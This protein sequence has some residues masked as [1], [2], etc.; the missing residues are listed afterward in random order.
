ME[1]RAGSG[2]AVFAQAVPAV[3]ETGDASRLLTPA[4]LA[5]AVILVLFVG[6]ASGYVL[7][8]P[9]WDNP[10][11]PAHYNY[12]R[13]LATGGGI[14][15]L[16]PGDW[17]QALLGG[18]MTRRF[19]PD[20]GVERLRYE[21]HQPPLYY[22]LM[23][24]FYRAAERLGTNARVVSLR[25]VNVAFAVATLVV[26][27]AATRVLLPRRPWLAV[28]AA[29]VAA[30]IPM[31]TAMSATI[32]NDPLSELLASATLFVLLLGVRD[33]FR[34]KLLLSLGALAGLLLLTKVTTYVFVV[35][36][37]AVVAVTSAPGWQTR[38][39]RLSRAG[40]RSAGVV[41][42]IATLLSG[43]WFVRG[44]LVYGP[45]DPLGL[46]RHDQVVVGQPRPVPG[47]EAVAF[48]LYSTSRSFWAQFGWM[49]VVV[50]PRLYVLA[51]LLLALAVL[52]LSRCLRGLHLQPLGPTAWG[53]RL[54][55]A[56]L[57][58]VAG[59]VVLYNFSF[60]QAQGRYLYPAILPIAV[61]VALGWSVLA[62]ED[63][64]AF[65]SGEARRRS[66]S[67]G[68]VTRLLACW[69]TLAAL[70]EGLAWA[71]TQQPAPLGTHAAGLAVAWLTARG[72]PTA[73]ADAGR[74]AVSL[75]LVAPLFLIDVAALLGHVVPFFEGR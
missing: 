22:L 65:S 18:L 37:V 38:G 35:L 10:D 13:Q 47:I 34:R 50:D 33:G 73:L 66:L 29:G 21:G 14:P 39:P 40:L 36:A 57:V 69:W 56:S 20:E 15:V 43:W 59:Q 61:F 42:A 25:W 51:L 55:M 60:V 72:R 1:H 70:L 9:R 12:L 46:V 64:R 2:G 58:I 75:G 17:D 3:R 5:L 74:P 6:L 27:F 63:E 32:N 23:V 16:Q 54:L 71:L 7:G 26:T 62:V 53:L 11:E 24:P 45:T 68:F 8:T 4:R 28:S 41:I 52:G 44:V 49:A 67:A 30:F 48:F 31:H 19:Q